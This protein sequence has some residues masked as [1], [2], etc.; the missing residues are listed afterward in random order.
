MVHFGLSGWGMG[1][2][3]RLV[4]C[5]TVVFV[6]FLPIF[7]GVVCCPLMGR[8]GWNLRCVVGRFIS[9]LCV[10]TACGL[11]LCGMVDACFDVILLVFAGVVFRPLMGERGLRY[12]VSRFVS[13]LCVITACSL[14]W[15]GTVD[16]CFD[17]VI[18]LK[19]RLVACSALFCCSIGLEV[20][21]GKVMV[22]CLV[23]D[24]IC[25]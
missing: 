11:R 21:V 8:R 2:I 17:V 24:N 14:R 10:T 3:D 15:C 7:A 19:A 6:I 1:M 16:A 18:V 4:G 22:E 9:I 23:L 5:M 20:P 13:I 12:E 25:L